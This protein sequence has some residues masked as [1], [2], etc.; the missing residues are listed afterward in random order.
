MS[1]E[2]ELYE[3]LEIPVTATQEEIK[4]AYRKKAVQHHPDKGGDQ[5]MFKK[6]NAAYEILSNPEKRELYNQR[7]KTGLR[8]SGVSEDLLSSMFGNFFPGF[9]NVFGIFRNVR[10]AIRKTQATVY[11]LHISLEDLCT[12]KVVKL[13]VTRT[14]VCSC[15][16]QA[17]SCSECSGKGVK[18]QSMAFGPMV[19]HIQQ[20]CD[21]CQGQGKTGDSCQDCQN[22][23]KMDPKIFEIHLTPQMENGYKYVFNDEGNQA[24]GYEPGDFVAVILRKEHPVFQLKGNNL[25]YQKEI[26]L[27]EALC[28]HS[29]DIT[30][31]SGEILN[32]VNSEITDPSTVQILP[33][34]LGDGDVMEIHYRIEFPKKLTPEQKNAIANIL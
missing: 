30:H 16:D 22:G 13:K 23:I 2:T 12:R 10:N 26:T 21:K 11:P 29:F 31:P 9:S 3:I 34:G 25:V 7:G 20:R 17:P 27:K 18:I 32:V 8:D 14:R 28:G 6:L 33:K 4:K 15:Y 19:Q 24:K 1:V 5:E